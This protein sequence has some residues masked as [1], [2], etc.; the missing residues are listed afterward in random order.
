M[1]GEEFDLGRSNGINV[2][3]IRQNIVA[4]MSLRSAQN[5]PGHQEKIAGSL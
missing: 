3:P 1:R 5:D 2:F 4:E